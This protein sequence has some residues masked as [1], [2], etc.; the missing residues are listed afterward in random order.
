MTRKSVQNI[1]G[2]FRISQDKENCIMCKYVNLKQPCKMKA[3]C[4]SNFCVIVRVI[5]RISLQNF[6][7]NMPKHAKIEKNTE[8]GIPSP[9]PYKKLKI[10]PSK[11][12]YPHPTPRPIKCFSLTTIGVL[13]M[14]ICANF[15]K[16]PNSSQEIEKNTTRQTKKYPKMASGDLL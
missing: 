13:S 10:T 11:G 1:R 9:L 14:I 8:N 5:P 2:I 15:D 3:T 12:Q 4:H 7:K 16:K 6:M